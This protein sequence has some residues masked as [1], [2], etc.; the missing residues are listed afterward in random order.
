M[1]AVKARHRRGFGHVYLRCIGGDRSGLQ[2]FI[3]HFLQMFQDD[4]KT[5]KSH[6]H[7]WEIGGSAEERKAAAFIKATWDQGQLVSYYRGCKTAP[8]R[9]MRMGTQVRFFFISGPAKGYGR[10]K[11]AALERLPGGQNRAFG[12][13][14]IRV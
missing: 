4:P 9:A 10:W 13:P 7:D 12:W 8:G 14:D 11:S 5:R 2:T 3:G 6:R 1:K